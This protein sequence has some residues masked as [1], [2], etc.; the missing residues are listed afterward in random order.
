MRPEKDMNSH[1]AARVADIKD[2]TT[3]THERN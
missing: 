2:S 1:G 3:T